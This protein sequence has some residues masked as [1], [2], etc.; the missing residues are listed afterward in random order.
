ME[1]CLIGWDQP[2]RH[3]ERAFQHRDNCR[4]AEGG[5]SLVRPRKSLMA[6]VAGGGGAGTRQ[7]PDHSQNWR[8]PSEGLKWVLKSRV[9]GSDICFHEVPHLSYCNK[10]GARRVMT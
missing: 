4:G 8:P 6:R 1:T 5:T 2:C 10:T 7:E 9:M 3:W